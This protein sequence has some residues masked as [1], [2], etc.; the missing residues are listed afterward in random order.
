MRSQAVSVATCN[1]N[2]VAVPCRELFY[3]HTMAAYKRLPVCWRHF[4]I[5]R[6]LMILTRVNMRFC[7]VQGYS[8]LV[9]DTIIC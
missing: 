2:T 4:I 1:A 5:K 7:N 9:K 3:K 8:V 6:M